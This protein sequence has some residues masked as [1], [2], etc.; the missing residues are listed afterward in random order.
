M[1]EE[2]A[3]TQQEIFATPLKQ[4]VESATA[5]IG[6]MNADQSDENFDALLADTQPRMIAAVQKFTKMLQE[7]G[8]S[9]RIVGTSLLLR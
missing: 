1:L 9:T 2:L 5:L 8:A 3:P 4:A 6:L 7:A